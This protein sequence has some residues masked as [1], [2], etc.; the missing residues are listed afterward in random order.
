[1][2]IHRVGTLGGLSPDVLDPRFRYVALGHIHR[3]YRVGETW[4]WYSGSP[5]ALSTKEGKTPRVVNLVT[6]PETGPVEVERLLVPAT[7]P[8]LEVRG[9]LAQVKA[10]LESLHPIG[11]LPPF[12]DVSIEVP[13]YQIG[14]E[15]E[16]RKFV[17]QL[18]D[19]P[20]LV[21]LRQTREAV[22]DSSG[23]TEGTAVRLDQLT[24]AEVFRRLCVD[25]GEHA[26]EL[27][28]AFESL[29]SE[30]VEP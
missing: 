23:K 27:M 7:R 22:R 2:E 15:E 28:P 24:P 16:I 19:G 12:V 13:S 10:K 29:L 14:L 3:S 30:Q 17:L 6:V 9:D 26:D 20:V 18:A 25:R 5:I 4:A 1:M 11:T 21:D 8:V